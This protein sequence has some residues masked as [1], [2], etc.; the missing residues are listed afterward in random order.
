ME[1]RKIGLRSLQENIDITTSGGKLVFHLST[2]QK[3]AKTE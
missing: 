1:K 3:L 2:G